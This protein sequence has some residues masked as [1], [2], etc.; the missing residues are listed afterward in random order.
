MKQKELRESMTN[1]V[2]R[3]G[4][5]GASSLAGKEVSDELGESLLG[6][7]DFV[8]LDDE[9][10]AGQI[11]AA[12]DEVAFIQRLDASSFEGMDFVFF[13]GRG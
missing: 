7:S 2:Y 3:V 6:G 8:L 12:G 5:V 13:C 4:I 9:D 11:T 10:A 1:K